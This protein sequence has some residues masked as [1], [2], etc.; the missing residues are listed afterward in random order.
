M[1]A[2]RAELVTKAA[3]VTMVPVGSAQREPSMEEILA[4]IR[5][6]IEDNDTGRKQPDGGAPAVDEAQ[7]APLASA[8]IIA[9][10]DTPRGANLIDAFRS[11]LRK[12]PMD[13][14]RLSL[15]SERRPPRE[16][17]P[18]VKPVTLAD[19]QAQ[20]A[21]ESRFSAP[22][23]RWIP[24]APA[25][26]EPEPVVEAIEAVEEFQPVAEAAA[27]PAEAAMPVEDSLTAS[28]ADSL[29][30]A[31]AVTSAPAIN[32]IASPK[33]S[34]LSERAERQVAAS[35]GELSEAFAARSKKTFDE[36][37]E[38]MMRPM[39]QDWLDNNLPV[40]VER[41]VREEIERVARG[42]Q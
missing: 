40:L 30:E 41:L 38:D 39:L 6:I 33:S 36:L 35:F 4:S 42:A 3:D 22:P 26:P 23:Q 32:A 5:R 19:V 34:I 37:A 29:S 12:P 24:D 17:V 8:T 27:E 1:T 7:H 16:D 2:G 25:A 20:I 28:L 15:D 21:A 9:Q 18:E 10:N 13:S 31:S 11:E 14:G